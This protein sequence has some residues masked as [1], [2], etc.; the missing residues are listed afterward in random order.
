[1][2]IEQPDGAIERIPLHT[3][4]VVDGPRRS[5]ARWVGLGLG[6]AVDLIL[7]AISYELS[8][9]DYSSSQGRYGL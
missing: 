5:R 8:D 7:I 1:M 2:L 6:L 3:V 9:W 4:R